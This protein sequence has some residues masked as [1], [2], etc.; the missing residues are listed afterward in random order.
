[1]VADKDFTPTFSGK[2][3]N[4]ILG[5]AN[6]DYPAASIANSVKQRMIKRGVVSEDQLKVLY[7]SQT[8][9]TTGYGHVH[10]LKPELAKKIKD[11]FFNFEWEGS[12]LKEEFEKN[13]EGKFI[14]ITYKEH[15]AVI[16]TIDKANN[17]SY[18]CK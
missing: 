17:V 11:A 10:N 5:V 15:W 3:D 6:K 1:M 4:S 13:G 8:F 2:H 14:P 18:A 7:K 9:P 16:R 12:S